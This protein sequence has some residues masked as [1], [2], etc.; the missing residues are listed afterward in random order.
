MREGSCGTHCF[1]NLNLWPLSPLLCGYAQRRGSQRDAGDNKVLYNSLWN[2][3]WGYEM[4]GLNG[5]G[6][7]SLKKGLE[8]GSDQSLFFLCPGSGTLPESFLF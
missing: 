2:V 4:L 8:L 5:E 6:M 1:H 7:S 3:I